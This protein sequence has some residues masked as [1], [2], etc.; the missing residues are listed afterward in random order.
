[1]Y[2]SCNGNN[3]TGKKIY[4]KKEKI[5]SKIVICILGIYSANVKSEE[6]DMTIYRIY[7]PQ[8]TT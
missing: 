3:Y 1:M 6:K 7:E 4:R 8:E 2:I 5:K